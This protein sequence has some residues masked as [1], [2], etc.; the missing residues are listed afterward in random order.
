MSHHRTIF[1]SLIFLILLAVPFAE[2]IR[3][4]NSCTFQGLQLDSPVLSNI[5]PLSNEQYQNCEVM[6]TIDFAARLVNGSFAGEK[7]PF[8]PH[9]ELDVTTRFSL[10]DTSVKVNIDYTCSVSD[11]CDL[12]FLRETLSPTLAAMQVEPVRQELARRLY[13]PDYTDPIECSNE[14]L[15]PEDISLCY[16]EYIHYNVTYSGPEEVLS[17][18]ARPTDPLEVV[19]TQVYSPYQTYGLN[20]DGSFQCNMPKCESNTTIIETFQWL[21]GEYQLSLNLSVLYVTTTTTTTTTATTTITTTVVSTTVSATESTTPLNY[22]SFL[23]GHFNTLVP[24][25]VIVLFLYQSF[26]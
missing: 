20:N 11:Y 5:C 26:F 7:P 19:W 1:P 12:E 23:F 24:C 15:C 25:F 8:Q 9:D 2:S 17:R 18:C 4:L 22:G 10:N 13:N 6:L 14:G 16:T 3:C 21:A